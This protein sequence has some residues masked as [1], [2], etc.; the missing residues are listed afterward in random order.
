LKALT[1]VPTDPNSIH[2]ARKK[3]INYTEL[4]LWRYEL[5]FKHCYPRLDIHVS[6]AR[7]HLLKSPFCIHPKT[8]RVC[9]PFDAEEVENFDPFDVPTVRTLC[10]EVRIEYLSNLCIDVHL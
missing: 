6:K 10:Q 1:T 7:N 8:G 2:A 5:V 9:V 3:R 4:E